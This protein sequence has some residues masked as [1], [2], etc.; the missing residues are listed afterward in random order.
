MGERLAEL[1]RYAEIV[2]ESGVRVQV[3]PVPEIAV[4]VKPAG[5]VSVTVTCPLVV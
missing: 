3:Q 5:K 1:L 4:A 2:Q